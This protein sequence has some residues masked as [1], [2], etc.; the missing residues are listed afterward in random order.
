MCGLRHNKS[1]NLTRD[2]RINSDQKA[3]IAFP[4]FAFPI[5]FPE[6]PLKNLNGCITPPVLCAGCP[7]R[8]YE[9]FFSVTLFRYPY[10][11]LFFC[12]VI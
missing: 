10:F 4:I 2:E 9:N 6:S 7:F 11:Y 12:G 5:A 1:T 8:T 3:L